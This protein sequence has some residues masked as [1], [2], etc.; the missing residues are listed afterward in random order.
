MEFD[1]KDLTDDERLALVG[2]IKVVIQADRLYSEEEDAELKKVAYALGEELFIATVD[3]A[4]E[5]FKSLDAI[6]EHARTVER[7]EAREL[8]LTTVQEIAVSDEVSP[9]E[10]HV[11]DW[12][13]EMWG[14]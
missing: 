12:L 7:Q 10:A 13:S 3:Q 9:E 4:R 6:K 5:R 14:F 8:I 2:L 1:F 11:V